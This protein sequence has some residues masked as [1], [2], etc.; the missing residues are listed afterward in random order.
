MRA[1]EERTHHHDRGRGN[2]PTE[3][4]YAAD[5]LHDDIE[6]HRQEID[7][8][9]S[10]L[11]DR[12][13][14]RDLGDQLLHQLRAGPGSYVGH[15]SSAAK[16]NPIPLALVGVGLGWLMLSGTDNSSGV[17]PQEGVSTDQGGARAGGRE[18]AVADDVAVGD[19]YAY[20]LRR[21]YPFYDDEI[22]CLLYD[23]LGPVAAA[24][25]TGTGPQGAETS[26]GG[27]RQ[28]QGDLGERYR[29][30]ARAAGGEAKARIDRTR[31][32]MNDATEEA[33][34]RIARARD[35]AKRRAYQ[36]KR[37]AVHGAKQAARQT[38]EFVDRY[39]LSLVA[40]GVAAG[41]ALGAG[42]PSTRTE[43]RWMGKTSDA[44]MRSAEEKVRD[45]A[46]TAKDTAK[47][48][49]DAA[50]DEAHRQ[51]VHPDDL[52]A[53]ARRAG[54][55]VSDEAERRGATG[56]GVR[57]RARD[58]RERVEEVAGAAGEAAR[59]KL[60]EPGSARRT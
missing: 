54:E 1:R 16:Q 38:T 52:K 13:S 26:S 5:A 19:L 11:E 14:L 12:L 41:A 59:R 45:T 53:G 55:K 28:A 58:T 44:F 9:L 34:M 49:A 57:E 47:A 50:A 10:A 37:A 23:D 7:R 21:E 35:N 32:R 56:G 18:T 51:G 22:E 8:T 40:L 33:K 46:D 60:E 3:W 31:E 48:A 15:L 43:D 27:S 6:Y 24:A 42:A 20:C 4:P 29:E 17:Q 39:P 36:A 30:Q 2:G 25:W